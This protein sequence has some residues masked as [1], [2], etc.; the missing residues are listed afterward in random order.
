LVTETCV[1]QNFFSSV[2]KKREEEGREVSGRSHFFF[3][4]RKLEREHEK[5]PPDGEIEIGAR[6]V[7]GASRSYEDAFLD[8]E[9][10]Y[11][12]AFKGHGGSGKTTAML[13]L[14]ERAERRGMRVLYLQ[15][16]HKARQEDGTILPVVA[17]RD[18]KTSRPALVAETLAEVE[19]RVDLAALDAVFVDEGWMW[20]DLCRI[21]AW[22][23]AV[24]TRPLRVAVAS[25]AFDYQGYVSLQMAMLLAFANR[26][27]DKEGPCGTPGCPNPARHDQRVSDGKERLETS[28]DSYAPRCDVCFFARE[29]ESKRFGATLTT[30][31]FGVA[32]AETETRVGLGG[33][34]E[35]ASVEPAREEEEDEVDPDGSLGRVVWALDVLSRPPT[36][37]HPIGH[38]I[39]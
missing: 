35:A 7:G 2:V 27:E 15:S 12:L 5:M 37:Y 29:A 23:L 25:I 11:V 14:G 30:F 16:I 13:A 18:G 38:A 4:C 8:A 21:Q 26:V 6:A 39:F 9:H 24:R 1:G 33:E 3:V 22:K 34:K 31:V 20:T 28:V 17:T 32:A 36:G 10:N 19:S